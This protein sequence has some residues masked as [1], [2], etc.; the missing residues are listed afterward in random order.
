[1]RTFWRITAF[2]AD[3]KLLVAVAFGAALGQ[4]A[5]SLTIPLFTRAVINDAL[6]AGHYELLVPLGLALLGI[7]VARFVLALVRRLATGHVSL[8]I[9]Y[10]LRNRM[11]WHL[12]R[13]PAGYFDRWQTGQLMS[14]AMSDIQNVRMFS[15]GL[16]S[17]PSTRSPWSPSRCCC[18]SSTGRW[19][20]CRSPSCPAA[21][22]RAALQ[23]QATPRATRRAAEDRRRLPRRGERDRSAHREDLRPR[24][25]RAGK[26]SARSRAVF[27][28]SISA[29]GCARSTSR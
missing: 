11:Y 14:R 1:M 18:S 3:Y 23:P 26:F 19:R 10:T 21:H 5:L 24:G 20:S 4:M 17:S 22:R 12:L 28:A 13:Q 29:A 6:M 7:G 27:D 2:L 16:V 8:G 9:E 15:A 25:R